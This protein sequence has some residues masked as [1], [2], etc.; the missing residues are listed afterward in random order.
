M[1]YTKQ[2]LVNILR[3]LGYTQAANDALRE[4][5]EEFDLKKLQEFGERHG[6]SR[7]EVTDAMG[8]SP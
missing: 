6:I 5:P 8:G 3:R 1:A 7:D 4:M 2:W